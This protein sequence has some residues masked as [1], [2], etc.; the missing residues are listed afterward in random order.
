MILA[1][2]IVEDVDRFLDV[3]GT[4]G[5]EKRGL[6][7]SKGSTVFRDPTEENRVWALFDWDE[8]GWAQFV[9]DPDVPPILK[10]AG[11]VGKPQ[12][13]QRPPGTTAAPHLPVAVAHRPPAVYK[14][15]FTLEDGEPWQRARRFEWAS[16]VS[17]VTAAQAPSSCSG[18]RAIV[19]VWSGWTLNRRWCGASVPSGV[20][21]L[22]CAI[23][24]PT[25]TLCATAAMAR[26][27]THST[28][29]SASSRFA[30]MCPRSTRRA[31]MAVPARPWPMTWTVLNMGDSLRVR[32]IVL[33]ALDAG[34]S[35]LAG[36]L[37]CARLFIAQIP[38]RAIGG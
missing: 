17:A 28:T 37:G 10:E 25:G 5:A 20:A 32:A 7:G 3:F 16:S 15:T 1:T 9:S 4:K 6:H 8:A 31:L 35:R 26:S 23:Q 14:A 33:H 13:A 36:S 24:H 18:P 2:T 11:H 30:T 34:R 29:R 19:S 21:P 27:G 12:A 38:S 22:T